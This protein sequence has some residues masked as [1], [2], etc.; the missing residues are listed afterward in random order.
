M[1]QVGRGDDEAVAGL[2]GEQL[3]ELIRD[4]AGL[5]GMRRESRPARLAAW[6]RGR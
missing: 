6:L 2:G 1:R 4:L 5:P 3:L